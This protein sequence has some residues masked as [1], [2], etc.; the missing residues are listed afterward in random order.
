MSARAARQSATPPP[1]RFAART[2]DDARTAGRAWADCE[3]RDPRSLKQLG[4]PFF[5]VF[6]EAADFLALDAPD[7]ERLVFVLGDAACTRWRELASE[8][9]RASEGVEDPEPLAWTLK[10]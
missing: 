8:S 3:A 4:R 1:K 5:W 9:P 10:S 7:R 6:E 2:E